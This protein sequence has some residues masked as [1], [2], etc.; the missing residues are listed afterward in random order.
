[1][2]ATRHIDDVDRHEL[3]EL[4][5]FELCYRFD[6]AENPTQVTVFRPGFDVGEATSW[7]TVNR[8]ATVALEDVR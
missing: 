5:E 2:S 1:M 7:L 3:A 8:E 4:P 6:D